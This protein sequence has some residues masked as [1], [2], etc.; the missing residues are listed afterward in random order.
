MPDTRFERKMNTREAAE[1]TGMTAAQITRAAKS[2]P[3]RLRAFKAGKFGP[4][5]YSESDLNEW[6]ASMDTANPA[7]RTRDRQAT[8]AHAAHARAAK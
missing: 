4:Y 7:N 3:P 6:M 2:E 8:D 1:Y 5:F